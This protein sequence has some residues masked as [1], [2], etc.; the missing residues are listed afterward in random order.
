MD[1]KRIVHTLGFATGVEQNP[2]AKGCVNEQRTGTNDRELSQSALAFPDLNILVERTDP[3]L[4]L[5]TSGQA[6]SKAASP[7]VGA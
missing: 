1:D 2:K 7:A 5:T 3:V 4:Q 6:Q